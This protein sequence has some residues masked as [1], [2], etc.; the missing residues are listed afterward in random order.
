TS[1]EMNEEAY[2]ILK[3]Y[4]EKIEIYLEKDK[5]TKEKFD[6][7]QKNIENNLMQLLETKSEIEKIDMEN[8]IPKS[9]I[10]KIVKSEKKLGIFYIITNFLIGF[11]KLIFSLVI[12]LLKFIIFIIKFILL[13]ITFGFIIV[14]IFVVPLI[15]FPLI[16]DN[17]IIFYFIPEITKYGIMITEIS[18]ILFFIYFL[19]SLTGSKFSKNGILT[20]AIISL[21]IGINGL[22]YGGYYFLY[23]Y[24]NTY[25]KTEKYSFKV[26]GLKE[27]K[28]NGLNKFNLELIG[29]ID[30]K[31]CKSCPIIDLNNYKIINS[32]GSEL[33]IKIKTTINDKNNYLAGEYFKKVNNLIFVLEGNNLI[34]KTKKEDLFTET[35]PYKFL[36]RD[37]TI[38]KPADLNILIP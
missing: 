34:L 9:S 25:D 26:D 5:I 4:L 37:I 16:I 6:E 15:F 20:G 22:V 19:L 17:Q 23:N 33:E 32:T 2:L 12:I 10:L 27:I 38:N 1:F 8:I 36:R 3:S 11:L 14:F 24:S 30:K 28:L 13:S 31:N 35:V 7:I 29:F 21:I 18:F